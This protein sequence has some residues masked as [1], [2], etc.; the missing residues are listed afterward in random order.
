MKIR[1]RGC[2]SKYLVCLC[3]ALTAASVGSPLFG[4][5]PATVE[6]RIKLGQAAYDRGA[7]DEAVPQWRQAARLYASQRNIKGQVGALVSLS[8]AYQALGQH[9][10]AFRTLELA[11]QL[12]ETSPDQSSLLAAQNEVGVVCGCLSQFQRSEQTLRDALRAARDQ[13]DTNMTAAVLNNLGNL[14]AGRNKT[15]DALSAYSE[16]ANLAEQVANRL[17]AAKASANAAAVAA[18]AARDADA[19]RF[20]HA[21]R[22][23]LRD[24]PP[25]H[26]VALLYLRC[27]QTDWQLHQRKPGGTGLHLTQAEES[28][29][30]ALAIA[31]TL[32]DKRAMTYALGYL[33]HLREAGG[34]IPAALELTGRAAFVAQEIQLPDALYRWEWQTGRLHRAQG[35]RDA[36]ITAYR[37]ALQTL[38]PIRHDLLFGYG[39]ADTTFREA[40]SP[41]F[42]ELTD[43][44]LEKA[45]AVNDPTAVQRILREACDTVEQ[46]KSVELED[47]LQDECMNLMRAKSARIEN[48]GQ[49][50]AVVYIIPLA[51]RTELLVGI[52]SELKRV[53]VTVGAARLAGE[54]RAFRSHLEKRTTNEYLAEARGL[55]QWLIAPI[56]DLLDA[57][58]IQ[59]LVFVPDG[60]LRTIPMSALQDGQHFLIEQFA[61]AVTPGLTLLEPRLMRWSRV[62]ALKAGLSEATQDHASLPYVAAELDRVRMLFGGPTLMDREFVLPTLKKDFAHAQYQVVHF[63]THGQIDRDASQ[64]YLLTYDGKLTLNQLEDLLRPSQFH[65][66]AV[67]LL[68]LSAC[69]TAAGDDRAALGLAG[70][71]VKA[72]AR[73]V[74]ATLWSVHDE[75]TT[76]LMGEFYSQL[77]NDPVTTKARALQ[78]AQLKL[79]RD[80][81][82]DHPGYWA[83]Y[84]IIGNWL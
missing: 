1:G 64:S 60:A 18:R 63:A 36:A 65:G 54:V 16:S 61:V 56:R 38:Q 3:L 8:A 50:T 73:S 59:T 28:Y 84:L 51:D 29:Q 52:G 31:E 69:Q 78:L 22:E 4:N 70:V 58:G 81:R 55:Y 20:N 53:K 14:L 42:F 83:P 10:L 41:V 9:R 32:D 67:E 72:G 57:N 62:Q 15:D 75:S 2:P 23:G 39:P 26:D 34:N 40:V 46:L 71:A 82:F 66:A 47:Y 49:K 27:G 76:L 17:L 68:T 12:A 80:P 33:G 45:D 6:E 5:E 11:G 19:E 79:F 74:L 21:A 25:T 24:Q 30:Q 13:G 35:N 37:R 44:L 7:F 43:L 77:K 48:I